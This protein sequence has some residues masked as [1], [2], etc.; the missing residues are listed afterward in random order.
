MSNSKDELLRLLK[1]NIKN[2]NDK[3]EKSNNEPLDF[4]GS[5]LTGTNL[6]RANLENVTLTNTELNFAYLHSSNLKNAN[7]ADLAVGRADMTESNLSGANLTG[8]D[9]TNTILYGANLSGI[10]GQNIILEGAK[11]REANLSEA[12]LSGG[13]LS[14]LDLTGVNFNKTNITGADFTNSNLS[15]ALNLS[16]AIF[17][18][19]TVFPTDPSNLPTDFNT[20]GEASETPQQTES[21]LNVNLGDGI[22]QEETQDYEF[23]DMPPQKE[24][25]IFEQNLSNQE[26]DFQAPDFQTDESDSGFNEFEPFE[27]FSSNDF[28]ETTQQQEPVNEEFFQEDN[29]NLIE[30]GLAIQ[31]EEEEFLTPSGSLGELEL[32]DDSHFGDPFSSSY[33]SGSNL[34]GGITQQDFPIQSDSGIM[35]PNQELTNGLEFEET[36]ADF[37][38]TQEDDFAKDF[39]LYPEESFEQTT[40]ETSPFAA[41]M[42]EFVQEPESFAP[43]QEFVQKPQVIAS[44]PVAMSSAQLEPIMELLKNISNKLDNIETEQK[45]QKETIELLKKETN[46]IKT[47]S[48]AE[49]VEESISNKVKEAT[50]FTQK[51]LQKVESKVDIIA[52]SDPLEH[53]DNLLEELSDSISAEQQIIQSKIIDVSTVLESV[54]SLLET[55]VLGDNGVEGRGNVEIDFGKVTNNL[56][57][58]LT[59]LESNIREDQESTIQ[60]IEDL[61]TVLSVSSTNLKGLQETIG[62]LVEISQDETSESQV[63][64]AFYDFEFRIQLELEKNQ[65]KLTNLEKLLEEASQKLSTLDEKSTE[66]IKLSGSEEIRKLLESF[67]TQLSKQIQESE[68]KTGHLGN[69]VDDMLIQLESLFNLKL[70]NI[71]TDISEINQKLSIITSTKPTKEMKDLQIGLDIVHSNVENINGNVLDIRDNFNNIQGEVQKSNNQIFSI[72][73]NI[74]ELA[75]KLDSIKNNEPEINEELRSVFEH[76]IIQFN[77]FS[78]NTK[79]GLNKLN[80]KINNMEIE[81]QMSLKDTE[82]N[83]S[84]I[85]SM[86]RKL[87]KSLDGITDLITDEQ[88]GAKHQ[89]YT[90]DMPRTTLQPLILNNDFDNDY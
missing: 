83:I 11:L 84:K 14:N 37:E 1:S 45:D 16:T 47:S 10:N 69:A 32:D 41:P 48:K 66:I 68:E 30:P 23:M 38:L 76:L 20:T 56:H 9:L 50:I 65:N 19:T 7:M 71:S 42:Q 18:E 80:K 3:R 12:N 72:N 51:L 62:S 79:D 15:G 6:C 49:F 60:K 61:A 73:A 82:K 21:T 2:F 8:A 29:F 4:S 77:D 74:N 17:D 85:N 28:M 64:E 22:S 53:I 55:E 26:S 31:E 87:Y 33:E 36:E 25:L 40:S 90:A 34:V 46:Q 52:Q 63:F 78:D 39:G 44:A 81:M 58:M 59:N 67:K 89:Q 86:I 27:S 75:N 54:V 5:D 24:D 43:M 35:T 70:E 13:N 88:G 57:E